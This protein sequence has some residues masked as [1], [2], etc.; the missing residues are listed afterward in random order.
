MRAR[1]IAPLVAAVLGIGGGVATALV[2]PGD[3][4]GRPATSSD[5]LHLGIPLVDQDCSGKSLLVIG[6]G[7]TVAPLSSAI[8][9]SSEKALRY[10]RSDASCATTLGPVDKA[11]PEYVVYSGPYD[12][13]REP[14]EV[15]MSGAESGSFV[16]V[17]RSGNQ[18][19]V[20]CPCEIP[21][22]AAPRLFLGM[23]PDQSE[24][25]WIRGLQAMFNDDDPTTLPHTA[26]TGKYDQRT[27]D[28]V[29]G[30]QDHAPGKVT[31]RGTVEEVTWGIL[32]D[33]L[34]RNYDY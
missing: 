17:L 20:K 25:L 7:E 26:I 33:R 12:D 6:Y 21:G 16:T 4:H 32:T 11:A 14:C 9:N 31:E 29:A 5:P 15:R 3:D 10:L 28:L 24:A 8:A 27:S 34:C 13:R 2:M 23:D 22:S 19:L 1:V 30:F 18:Q